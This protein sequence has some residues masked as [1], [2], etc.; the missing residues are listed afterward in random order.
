MI[1]LILFFLQRLVLWGIHWVTERWSIRELSKR[2]HHLLKVRSILLFL[3]VPTPL[4]D[5]SFTQASLSWHFKECLLWP[6]WVPI[7][8]SHENLDLIRWLP[9]SLPDNSFIAILTTIVLRIV[10]IHIVSSIETVFII[11]V[12]INDTMRLRRCLNVLGKGHR[13]LNRDWILVLDGNLIT[14]FR[15]IGNLRVGLWLCLCYL[16]MMVVVNVFG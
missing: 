3:L 8:F 10:T 12:V 14:A 1:I 2:R 16:L 11:L 7:E 9:L 15:M 6:V 4:I 13:H 5:L